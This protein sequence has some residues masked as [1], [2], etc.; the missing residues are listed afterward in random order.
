VRNRA[1]FKFDRGGFRGLLHPSAKKPAFTKKF[2]KV[3]N[4]AFAV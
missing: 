2:A 4:H 3:I 1:P